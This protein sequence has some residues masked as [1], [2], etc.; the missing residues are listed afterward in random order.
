MD[1]ILI[2]AFKSEVASAILNSQ[3]TN[4]NLNPHADAYIDAEELPAVLEFFGKKDVNELLA[5]PN[6]ESPDSVFD[7]KKSQDEELDGDEFSKLVSPNN[8]VLN[9]EG[10]AAFELQ[11]QIASDLLMTSANG[12]PFSA[13]MNNLY[14][15]RKELIK[16]HQDTT[17]IDARIDALNEAVQEY[18]KTN[19]VDVTQTMIDNGSVKTFKYGKDSEKTGYIIQSFNLKG[20][21]TMNKDN[22]DAV[23]MVDNTPKTDES[24]ET[25]PATDDNKG[26]GNQAAVN[27]KYGVEVVTD[28]LHVIGNVEAG[29]NV[30]MQSVAVYRNQFK[31]GSTLSSSANLRGTIAKNDSQI[32]V[33]G[34]VDYSKNKISTGV[35]ASYNANETDSVKCKDFNAEA[36]VKYGNSVRLGAGHEA[37]NSGQD[38]SYKY[39]F[40]KAKFSGSRMVNPNLSLTGS[41]E[42]N[43]GV[44]KT[45]GNSDSNYGV[46]AK[47][48]LTFKSNKLKANMYGTAGYS[49]AKNAFEDGSDAHTITGTFVGNVSTDKMDLTATV[50]GMRSPQVS[51]DAETYDFVG[52]E[53]NWD[54]S[55][56]VTFTPKKL[57]DKKSKIVPSITYSISNS[58]EQYAGV[59]LGINL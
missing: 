15:T 28:K 25:T 27:L 24:G 10:S 56:S 29:D 1:K 34:S 52:V 59:H 13:Q 30:D 12:T 26:S 11:N 44:I 58:G 6:G 9:N 21:N 5:N 33:G 35:Y 46:F 40:V 22:S 53:N 32:A 51:L 2:T 7:E 49:V 16:K 47:G 36:Y 23:T 4:K 20:G 38:F 17:D 39:S 19:H 55:A 45:D 48:G 31:D 3:G 41:V 50:S 8:A 37:S 54:Y 18:I 42:G 57:L 14:E 43:Y